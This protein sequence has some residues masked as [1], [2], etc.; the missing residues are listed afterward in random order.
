MDNT[1]DTPRPGSAGSR[2][3]QTTS[4]PTPDA[5][6]PTAPL[7]VTGAATPPSGAVPPPPGGGATPPP[8]GGT[9]P[10][11]PPSPP[12][13]PP[14]SPPPGWGPDTGDRL[15]ARLRALRRSRNDRVVAG[16]CGGVARGLGID[17]LLLRVLVV[18]LT[19]FGGAGVVLYA[20]GWLLLPVDDGE[21]SLGTQVAHRHTARPSS[22]K[23]LLAIVLAAAVT[24]GVLS[25]FRSWD[26]PLLLS[27]AAV[28]FVVYLLRQPAPPT[29]VMG[30]VGAPAVSAPGVGVAGNPGAAGPGSTAAGSTAAGAAGGSRGPVTA[31][32]VPPWQGPPGQPPAPAQPPVPPPPAP[33]RER[34]M[35][36]GLTLSAVLLALGVLAAVDVSGADLA[37]GAYPATALTVVGLGLLVGAWRGRSRGLAVLGVVLAVMTL[38]AALTSPWQDRF[39]RN[40]GVDLNLRPTSVSELPASAEYSAGQVRYDLT[41]VPFDDESARLGAQIGFGEIVVTVPRTVDVTV[42]ARTGVGAVDVLNAG[43]RGGF[44]TERNITDVGPDGPG[45]GTLDLDLQA[46]FGHLEVRR[47]QA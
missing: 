22:Q 33:P 18:V 40:R 10:G 30:G 42:H 27:L 7:P 24:L 8:S 4:G 44:G 43:S 37:H 47:A 25:A 13:A 5:A 26:G 6:G 29:A 15:A 14:P 35:L 41:A 31:T 19:I 45:G 36:F 2:P 23:T 17:A 1:H 12:P 46:G 34:S 9:P 21:P 39:D 11:P 28:G 3:D 20:L 16:V 38:G 32:A